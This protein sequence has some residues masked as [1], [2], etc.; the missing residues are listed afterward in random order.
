MAS[1][2]SIQIPPLPKDT[3]GRWLDVIR[4]DGDMVRRWL[5]V[6]HQMDGRYRREGLGLFGQNMAHRPS[7]WGASY[8]Y[9]TTKGEVA[10]RLIYSSGR[11]QHFVMSVGFVGRIS[12]SDA[13]ELVIDRSIEYLRE[14]NASSAFAVAP[15]RMEY[16]G[17]LRLYDL[18]PSHHR[19]IVK[20]EQDTPASRTWNIEAPEL[21]SP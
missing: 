9:W 5:L 14:R 21:N 20:T 17:I 2:S 7:P 12:P 19:L 4:E 6:M 16:P 3:A 18:V 1:A 15:K 10:L 13:L 8:Y 11:K